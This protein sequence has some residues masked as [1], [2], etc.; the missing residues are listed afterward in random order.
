MKKYNLVFTLDYEIHGNGDGSPYLLMVEPTY[1]LMD[2]LEQYGCKL[3]IMA[4]VAEILCFKCYYEE[5]GDD[6][7]SYLRI[8]QQLKDAVLRGHDV[9]LH[10]HSS[11]FRATLTEQMTWSQCIEEYNMAAQHYARIEEMVRTCVDY[12][13]CLLRPLKPDYKCHFFRAANWSMMPTSNLYK[14]LLACGVDKDTSVYKGGCQGGNVCYDYSEAYS[15]LL[16][17]RA[18]KDNINYYDANGK[19]TE[20]PIYTE[21]RYFWNFISIIR[22]FRMIR[23]KFHKHKQQQHVLKMAEDK[24][25]NRKLSLRSFFV[26]SPW[27]LDFNQATGR[28]LIGALKRIMRRPLGNRE[29]VDII[30]IGHS[31]TFVPYNEKTLET[32]L[33]YVQKHKQNIGSEL[34]S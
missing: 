5:T 6:K 15:D 14:A 2:L 7:F 29:K 31:K 25:D 10:I 18:S 4:D 22:I 28:Q 11:Y 9:Q 16:S 27:K 8:E 12:L 32:F 23:A 26:K 3:T 33:K 30:L 17:Y 21:M 19:L 24:K 1:R 13:E 20:F 34:I